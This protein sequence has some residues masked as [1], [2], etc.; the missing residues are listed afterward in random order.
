M[1]SVNVERQA[2]GNASLAFLFAISFPNARS[3]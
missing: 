1:T 3:L 2:F